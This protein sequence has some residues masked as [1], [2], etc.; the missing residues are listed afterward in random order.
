MRTLITFFAVIVLLNCASMS[1]AISTYTM[2]LKA[3]PDAIVADGRSETTISAEVRDSSGRIVSDGTNVD[4]TS[5][6]GNI[7]RSARTVAGVARVRLQS[8]VTVGT[9]MVSAV[10]TTGNAVAQIRVDFLE[11]GTELFDESFI[12]VFSKKYL[13]YDS[14]G[15]IVDSAGGVEI[16]HRGLTINAEE[17]QIS[18]ISN[19]MRAKCKTG[20][21]N[22]V[23]RR[24]S[25]RIEASA[26]Y[27]DFNSM[28]GVILTPAAEG[29]KR[30]AFRGR[31]MFVLPVTDD[32]DKSRSLDYKPVTEA[33]MFVKAE[34]LVI[35]PNEEIKFKK[36]VFYMDGTKMLSVPLYVLNL[37]SGNSG[38]NQLITYGTDGLRL[39]VP[40]YY[41]LTPSTTGALRLRRSESSGWSYSS[42]RPGWQLDMEQDY[43]FG[44]TTEGTFLLN[45]ITSSRD[46]GAKWTQRREFSNDSQIYTYVDFPSHKSLYSSMSYSRS[47]PRYTF[48]VNGRANKLVDS[49]GYA[50]TDAY[51]Q[52]RARP[53]FGGALNYSLSSKISVDTGADKHFGTGCGLQL[54]GTPL[55]LGG[56]GN[57]ST[58]LIAASNWGPYAGSTLSANAGI[59]HNFKSTGS[60]GLNYSYAWGNTGSGYSQHRISAN[61]SLSPSDRWTAYAYATKGIT[62][63]SLSAFGSMSYIF[64]P[65][66]TLGVQN[67]Y[68]RFDSYDYSDIEFALAK[69]IGRQEVN[70]IWSSYTRRFRIEFSALKF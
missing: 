2:S 9:A 54:Y 14:N 62:D 47:L 30:M 45:Q 7:E 65:T 70:L 22:I 12:T 28:T 56:L 40:W 52:S 31:D 59:N 51:I 55:K 63:H 42:S 43:N 10:S 39:D 6:I 27:Y 32:V 60:L 58:S 41:S 8:T 66:W 67:T 48:S 61:L 20:V 57:V 35:R 24:E 21:N 15:G 11:P 69:G 3:H 18:V 23:I 38:T 34:S 50:A 25:K 19:I 44:G 1:S 46:W 26:L 29:A 36:A 17:A 53:I 49:S 37:K 68:Q 13:G 16:S 5:S 4:F 33:S 64:A